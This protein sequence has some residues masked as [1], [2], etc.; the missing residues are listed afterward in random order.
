MFSVNTVMGDIITERIFRRWVLTVIIF[1]FYLLFSSIAGLSNNY[2]FSELHLK[3]T[4]EFGHI[5]TRQIDNLQ[6]VYMTVI[7][8]YGRVEENESLNGFRDI[9]INYLLLTPEYGQFKRELIKYGGNVEFEINDD[10]LAISVQVHRDGEAELGKFLY[11]LQRGIS[12]EDYVKVTELLKK[13]R[14]RWYPT[15]RLFRELYYKTHPYA[16][17]YRPTVTGIDYEVFQSAF[18]D[19]LNFERVYIGIVCPSSEGC[20]RLVHSAQSFLTSLPRKER[21]PVFL[22][23]PSLEKDIYREFTL[24]D[25]DR[26]S[27]IMVYLPAPEAHDRDFLAYMLLDQILADGYTSFLFSD[28]RETTGLIYSYSHRLIPLI[29]GSY[30]SIKLEFPSEV[31]REVKRI[32]LSD[33]IPEKL[34]SRI[35]SMDSEDFDVYRQRLVWRYRQAVNSPIIL[36][37]YLALEEAIGYYWTPPDRLAEEINLI[38]R[39]DIE[40]VIRLYFRRKVFLGIKP[41]FRPQIYPYN[42]PHKI[43]D[44][45]CCPYSTESY[46][47]K[48]CTQYKYKRY[49]YK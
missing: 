23:P 39:D 30:Y 32:L 29:Y 3:P 25:S 43:I 37:K 40:R 27:V 46:T 28:L 9:F 10:W 35:D 22:P 48:I 21:V 42:Y 6:G 12:R 17:T 38:T 16:L 49:P 11:I 7:F 15:D 33:L 19:M 1:T 36:S 13:L 4:E 41:S 2:D 18:S 31:Y 47:A 24:K 45:K 8:R 34:I 20:T 5:I 44:Y 14:P 26:L